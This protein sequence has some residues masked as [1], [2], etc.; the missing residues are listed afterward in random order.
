MNSD[1]QFRVLDALKHCVIW[2]PGFDK[3]YKLTLKSINTTRDRQA[4]SSFLL[5]GPTGVGKSTLCERIQRSFGAEF[6][7]ESASSQVK[8]L[9]C[10]LVEVPPK[11][12][13]KTLAIRILVTL[14]LKDR[15]RLE[16]MSTDSLNS[17]ILQRLIT[18]KVQLIILDEFHRLLDQGQ[19]AS[20][21]MV[22]RTVNEIL[23][24]ACIPVMLV[25]LPTIEK[26]ID[27]ISE[28][29]DRYPYRA[30]L[31]HFDF[32]DI[33]A[34]AQFRKVISLIEQNVINLENFSERVSLTDEIIFK[35]ICFATDGNFRHLNVLLNDSLTIAVTRADNTLTVEDFACAADDLAFC[36]P[37]NPFRISGDK[38]SAEMKKKYERPLLHTN[39]SRV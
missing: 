23:N 14:G 19:I 17:M 27:D 6:V 37:I 4:A 33:A 3:A 22:C 30:H 11:A 21:K 32:A 34:T 38:L 26:L 10:L 36:K 1:D 9:P 13:I 39:T 12:T 35:A 16:Q 28:L 20:K 7:Q 31:R 15:E 8:T 29:S 24:Q 18:M 2:H 25:G 5:V